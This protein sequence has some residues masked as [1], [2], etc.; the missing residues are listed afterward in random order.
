MS[1]PLK[2]RIAQRPLR[3]L[4]FDIENRP[5]SYWYD[6]PTAEVTVIS[7]KWL[8]DNR[9]RVLLQTPD[10]PLRE[11]LERFLAVYAKA[12]VVVGHNIR[13]HDLPILHGA[14]IEQGMPGL[15][16]VLTI[17]TLRDLTGY[18]D[19]PKS[20]EYLAD[21]LGAPYD[22]FHMTQ[23][24][25]REA[26]RFERRGLRLAKKRCAV[27]VQVTEWVYLELVRRGLLTKPPRV[28]RP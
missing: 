21:M 16:A 17:D 27:D 18:K 3:A 2:L 6:R 26:N 7:Y 24:S 13:R 11:I 28:W 5:L 1:R 10:V 15:D 9:P 4:V 23:H 14:C 19:I 22:K 8:G 25:W 12:E 20:L